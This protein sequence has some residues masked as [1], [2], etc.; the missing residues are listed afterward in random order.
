VTLP[1]NWRNATFVFRHVW[2]QDSYDDVK[3]RDLLGV[4][5]AVESSDGA[6]HNH[7]G[8]DRYAIGGP[9]KDLRKVIERAQRSIGLRSRSR[10]PPAV[11]RGT[12]P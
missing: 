2:Y 1:S 11:N 12:A 9:Y 6:A 4:R 5:A 7:H 10:R 3:A 8:Y